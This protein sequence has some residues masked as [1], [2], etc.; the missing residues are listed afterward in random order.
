TGPDHRW[1]LLCWQC[2]GYFRIC[3]TRLLLRQFRLIRPHQPRAADQADYFARRLRQADGEMIDLESR[4]DVE[5][6][7]E[8]VAVAH[9]GHVG[10]HQ[11]ADE[12]E[13]DGLAV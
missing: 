10:A 12:Q 7:G 6:A 5:H 9:E 1:I 3:C 8:I 4:K 2:S 13:R 11:L